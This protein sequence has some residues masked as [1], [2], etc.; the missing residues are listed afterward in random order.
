MQYFA[1]YKAY[2]ID[3]YRSVKKIWKH[4]AHLKSVVLLHNYFSHLLIKYNLQ[5][6]KCTKINMFTDIFYTIKGNIKLA[7]YL[8]LL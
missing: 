3:F 7:Y 5:E 6:L 2:C 4:D 1:L 8:F